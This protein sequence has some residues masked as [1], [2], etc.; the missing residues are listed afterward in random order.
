M[1]LFNRLFLVLIPL[2]AAG[3]C[4]A[5]GNQFADGLYPVLQKANC[6]TCHVD[7]GIASG[8]RLHFPEAGAPP[9]QVEAFGRSL[10]SL[11]NRD[12]PEAS[13]LFTKPTNRE[14]HTGGKLIAPG[15][16][17]EA[18]LLDWVRQ[19]ARLAPTPAP[20]QAQ[21]TGGKP[22][23]VVMRR[24]THSQYNH[25][26]RDLLGDQTNP[27]S[28]FP[29]ED[30]VNGFQNQADAQSI[31]ALLAE[32]Y[33]AAAEKLARNAFRGGD[34]NGLI[35]CKQ[36]VKCRAQ[37]VREFGLKAFRRPLTDKEVERYSKLFGAQKDFIAGAQ[38]VVEA[39]LQSPNFL[40]RAERGGE[41]RSYAVA[42]RLSYFLWDT[43]PDAG[44]FR[45]AASG[46]LDSPAGVEKVTRRMLADPRARQSLDEFV[47]QWLRFDRVLNTVKDRAAFPL[48]NPELAAAMTEETRLLVADAVWNDRDF[49]TIFKSDYGFINSDLANLYKFP[50]PANEFQRVNFPADTDRAGLLGQATFLALTSK[51]ADTS[52]TARGLFV[53]E[54]FLC[55]HVPDPP[56]GTNSNL[57]PVTASK[58]LTNR[59]RLSM[60]LQSPVC[61]SCHHLIDPIGFGFEKFDAIGGRR[62]KLVLTFRGGRKEKDVAPTKA[63]LPLDTSGDVAGIPNSGFHSPKEL[64]RV[65]SESA[66]CQQCVVKQLFRFAFGRPETAADR[67]VIEAAFDNFRNSQFRFKEL[68]VAMAMAQ[69]GQ[70]Y[71][72]QA[73]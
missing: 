9:D 28:Q 61:A 31:P 56:P 29:T 12:Q 43:M 23:Q 32:A 62:E 71:I 1:R 37:F 21:T 39:M 70:D 63:E 42:S 47:T 13:L 5:A 72:L 57:P 66:E 19:L 16:K 17:E 24:L 35:P 6:R 73:D 11:V 14:K 50:A 53:R 2:A 40:F 52:P 36:D 20:A 59:E 48:F 27:A 46:E 55:Q 51:P 41:A 49:M 58:P 44:L 8:T 68:I 30:F 18:I 45:S 69:V 65:L 33:G 15:S 34:T 38:L 10:A 4:A 22:A 60:H 7:G 64:G 3:F 25:T 26:V 54:Q 67:P